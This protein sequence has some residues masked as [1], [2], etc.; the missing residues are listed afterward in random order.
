MP[1]GYIIL[2][3]PQAAG[4]STA[5]NYISCNYQSRVSPESAQ[6]FGAKIPRYAPNG[7]GSLPTNLVILQEMR[8]MVLRNHSV[9]GGVFVDWAG[10]AEIIDKDL[11]RL[12]E[13]IARKDNRVYIDETNIFTLAHA[14]F[15]NI[16]IE[17]CFKEYI[18]RLEQTNP[19]IIFLDVS[20]DTSWQRRKSRY[21]ERVMDF[22]ADAKAKALN[23]YRDYLKKIHQELYKFYERLDL[24]K[25]M[26]NTE[27]PL[28]DVLTEI[29]PKIQLET[30]KI[31]IDLL[32]R[33]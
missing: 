16:E 31:G 10:E 13:I 30:E 27:K 20:P 33:L 5:L 28:E 11:Q 12:D 21:E 9:P 1:H 14:Q 7:H 18:K 22:P 8:Q 15:H 29:T 3:G 32:T 23:R 4:K 17:P 24:P 19:L 2:A 26:I 25:V 6:E